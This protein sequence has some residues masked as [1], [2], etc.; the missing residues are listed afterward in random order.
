MVALENA[1]R[2]VP[3]VQALVATYFYSADFA[4]EGTLV[5]NDFVEVPSSPH[6]LELSAGGDLWVDFGP[7]QGSAPPRR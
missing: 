7:A 6:H 5:L 1:H 2:V 4:A 3:S